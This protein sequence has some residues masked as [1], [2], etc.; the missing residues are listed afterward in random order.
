MGRKRKRTDKGTAAE[1]T[2]SA[3]VVVASA[4]PVSPVAAADDA[5]RIS[6]VPQESLQAHDEFVRSPVAVLESLKIRVPPLVAAHA[7]R[8]SIPQPSLT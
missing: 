7:R 3:A 8:S 2:A 1:V 5:E 6:V 4:V